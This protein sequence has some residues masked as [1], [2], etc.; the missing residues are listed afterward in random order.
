MGRTRRLLRR[1]SR[2]YWE[3]S[4]AS[5]DDSR[6]VEVLGQNRGSDRSNI[7]QKNIK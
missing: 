7:L 5:H 4:R 2:L 3:A 1:T 6:I